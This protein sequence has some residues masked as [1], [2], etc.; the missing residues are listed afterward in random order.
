MLIGATYRGLTQN[1][2]PGLDSV[3][4]SACCSACPHP[5]S[6]GAVSALSRGDWGQAVE[7]GVETDRRSFDSEHA[8]RQPN[9]AGRLLD[10]AGC[11]QSERS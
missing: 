6:S 5:D 11:K 8:A 2:S 9:R 1:K 7:V 4:F 10:G 3:T